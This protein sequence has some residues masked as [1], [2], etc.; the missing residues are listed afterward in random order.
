MECINELCDK[1]RVDTTRDA[2][3]ALRWPFWDGLCW[4]SRV[5]ESMMPFCCFE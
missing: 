2:I 5:E 4:G 3:L 1:K